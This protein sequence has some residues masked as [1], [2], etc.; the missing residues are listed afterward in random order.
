MLYCEGPKTKGPKNRISRLFTVMGRGKRACSAE[1]VLFA[2]I[3]AVQED[4][5]NFNLFKVP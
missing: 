4:F 5:C 2:G 1:P 3:S